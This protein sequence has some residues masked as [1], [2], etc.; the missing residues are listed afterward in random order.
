MKMSEPEILLLKEYLKSRISYAR[1]FSNFTWHRM[2]IHDIKV[3]EDGG[4]A[5]YLLFDGDT[6]DEITRIE[7]YNVD[8][9]LFS[10]GETRIDKSA[11]PDG[12]LYRYTIRIQQD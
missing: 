6:P 1:Y 9:T 5:T 10:S 4:V 2:E 12:I 7:I 3:L 11:F 8:G